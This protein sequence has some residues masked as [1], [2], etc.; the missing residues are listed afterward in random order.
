MQTD[1]ELLLAL[2]NHAES[3]KHGK[4]QFLKSYK[5]YRRAKIAR[6]MH[7]LTVSVLK[8]SADKQFKIYRKGTISGTADVTRLLAYCTLS[9]AVRFYEE[10]LS[11]IADMITEYE[12]YLAAGNW[13]D[14]ILGLQRPVSKLFD[15]RGL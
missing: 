15:Y 10:E 2:V 7:K 8:Q 5:E 13:L 9:D 14:F 11:T 3:S 12:C 1:K 4:F 6:R